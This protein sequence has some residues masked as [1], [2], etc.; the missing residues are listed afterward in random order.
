[1]IGDDRITA[2]RDRAGAQ[3]IAHIERL[4]LLDRIRV[5]RDPHGGAHHGI[6]IDEHAGAQEVIDRLLADPIARRESQQCGPFISGVVVNVHIGEGFS[7]LRDIG[8]EVDQGLL[9]L[10]AVVRP[11]GLEDRRGSADR[12]LD[13]AEEILQAPLMRPRLGPHRVALEVEEDVARTR[14]G[15]REQGDRIDDLRGDRARLLLSPLQPSLRAHL[16]QD[17]LG[18]VGNWL[19]TRREVSHRHH[20]GGRQLLALAGV[21]AGDEQHI[22]G[23]AQLFL[24]GQTPTAGMHRRVAP[25]RPQSAVLVAVEQLQQSC[26]PGPLHGPDHGQGVCRPLTMPQH[27]NCLRGHRDPAL[28]QLLG[29]RSQLQQA[30]HRLRPGEFG[31]PHLPPALLVAHEE[32]GQADE[33][34]V[35]E[36]RLVDN[37]RLGGEGRARGGCRSV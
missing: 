6:Q 14:R 35:G 31:V 3:V 24:A 28:G 18:Q 12:R 25:T 13:N 29:I 17:G 36:G 32:V 34:I 26:T 20:A 30:G 33:A 5:L 1:M 22:I 19:R 21:D 27:E 4:E 37:A 9:L 16:A 7:P 11:E 15:Q 8:E 23:G 10:R 2:G